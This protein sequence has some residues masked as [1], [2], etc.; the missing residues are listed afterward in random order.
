MKLVKLSYT[1]LAGTTQKWKLIDCTFGNVNLIVGKNATGKT[2]TVGVVQGLADLLSVGQLKLILSEGSYEVNFENNGEAISYILEWHNHTIT[3]ELLR[4]NS[5][6]LLTRGTGTGGE[7]MI[8]AADIGKP[9]RFQIP[10]NQVAVF[11]KRDSIQHPFLEDI[12]QWGKELIRYDFG[13]PLGRDDFV[14]LNN[15]LHKQNE[16]IQQLQNV[17]EIFLRGSKEYPDNFSQAIIEDFKNIFY[18]IEDIGVI[19]LQRHPQPGFITSPARIYVKE[20]D[21]EGKTF[22]PSMSQ[23]MF[24]ALSILIQVNYSLMS[25]KPSCILIDDIGEG[26]DFSRSSAL[27]NM[28]IEKIKDSSTQLIMATNDRFVM[29]NVPLE[30][31]II[32]DKQGSECIQYNYRNSKQM[33]DEFEM[34][35]LSNF[36]LFSSNYYLQ[37]NGRVVDFLNALEK[38]LLD[39][40]SRQS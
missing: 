7:G 23:G 1:E 36:D 17:V 4:V 5:T 21:R 13:T 19:Q 24:R 32:M 8:Y 15:P 29:N 28:L 9:I 18:D 11:T 16:E 6:E 20:A 35:G 37:D 22:Q 27:I 31:W 3:R 38:E 26:L 30:Y 10:T 34:T 33:F 12:Y 39:S 2:K 25:S 40:I 14:I